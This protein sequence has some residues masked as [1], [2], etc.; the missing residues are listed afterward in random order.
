MSRNLFQHINNSTIF[1]TPFGMLLTGRSWEA[2]SG[3]R[4]GFGG[5]EQDWGDDSNSEHVNF[6]ERILDTRI[7]KF[8]SQDKFTNKFP[9]SSPYVFA[10]NTPIMATDYKG[11]STVYM[12]ISGKILLTSFDNLPNSVV[13]V[14]DIEN[15][16]RTVVRITNGYGMASMDGDLTNTSFRRLGDNYSTDKIFEFDDKYKSYTGEAATWLNQT[17]GVYTPLTDPQK[18]A[19]SNGSTSDA[20][21]EDQ[22]YIGAPRIHCHSTSA[23]VVP[24]PSDYDILTHQDTDKKNNY[25]D[26]NGFN[27]VVGN[28]SKNPSDGRAI[29]FY[30]NKGLFSTEVPKFERN[31]FIN[32]KSNSVESRNVIY[33]ETYT[34]GP[35][36]IK[37]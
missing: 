2:G 13:I 21:Y 22:P 19:V 15:F 4:Y 7:G 33:T 17:D 10:S 8:I 28:T 11:D 5:N 3:Y 29:Y 37:K 31:Y 34:C 1:D 23:Y 16:R 12:S 20:R 32:Q 18:I 14:E 35:E 25:D 24:G 9:M 6:G 30:N 26:N 27:I 36:N